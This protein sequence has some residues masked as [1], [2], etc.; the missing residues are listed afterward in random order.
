MEGKLYE[1]SLTGDVQALNKLLHEDQL[2]LDRLSLTAYNETPLHI[3]AMRGHSHFATVILTQKPKLGMALDTQRRTPLHLA[4]ANGNLEMVQELIRLGSREVCCFKDQDGL[5]PLHLAAMN[6]HLEVVKVLVKAY[7]QAAKEIPASGETILHMC[8][9][10]NRFEALKQLMNIWTEEELAMIIDHGGNT[11][12]HAAA[13]NKQIHILNYL[14]RIPSIKGNGNAVNRHGLTALD[15]LDQCPRDLK[16]LETQHILLEAGVLRADG[17]RPPHKPLQISVNFT[18]TKQKG[19]LA[20]TW[21]RYLN[22][23]KQ[24][25]E[26]QRGILILAA[27][28]VAVMSFHSGINPPGGTISDTQNGP[29]GNAVLT[30]VDM[31][32]FNGFV[33][34]NTIT[35]IISLGIVVILI[36]GF[37]L[38]NKFWMWVLTV[39]TLFTVVVMVA[40]YL[41][42]L[43]TMAPDGYVDGT[44][45]WICLILMLGCGVV[46]LIHTILFVVWVVMKLS[47]CRMPETEATRNNSAVEV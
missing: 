44:S 28:V 16:A 18:Q 23:D 1:A 40:N 15:V 31:D 9:N 5:T 3:A 45:I 46:A 24:W 20:R 10:Y 42:S 26:K 34:Y 32:K 33:M 39:G 41:E 43:G 36:S 4:S 25:L 29:L 30:E 21:A 12:L 37:S 13:I 17:L 47:K 19:L 14:L 38:R 7:P 35:M 8:I 2:I 22:D 11:L 27:L 6:E